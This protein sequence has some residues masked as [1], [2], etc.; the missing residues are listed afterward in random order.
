MAP[1]I[2]RDT[3]ISARSEKEHL[4]L[5]RIRGE[6]PAVAED[7]RL[8]RTPVVVVNLRAVLGSD[9][10]H[11]TTPSLIERKERPVKRKGAFAGVNL[12]PRK[13]RNAD[14]LSPSDRP[15]IW[16][17]DVYEDPQQIRHCVSGRFVTGLVSLVGCGQLI[18][19]DG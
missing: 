4:V 14:E 2:M 19:R 12:S 18:A 5:E 8:P 13:K 10:T 17:R 11:V 9:R 16:L 7:Y 15:Q 6:R 3:A 1:S